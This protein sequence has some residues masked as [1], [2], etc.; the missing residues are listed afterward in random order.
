MV[1][2]DSR[3]RLVDYIDNMDDWSN[4]ASKLKYRYSSILTIFMGAMSGGELYLI[5]TPDASIFSV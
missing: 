4:S 3:I 2:S 1:E 5:A